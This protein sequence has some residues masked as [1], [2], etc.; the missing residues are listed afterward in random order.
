MI[1]LPWLWMQQ[2]QG[3]KELLRAVTKDVTPLPAPECNHG[4]DDDEGPP[5]RRIVLPWRCQWQRAGLAKCLAELRQRFSDLGG[6]ASVGTSWALGAPHAAHLI[7]RTCKVPSRQ[8]PEEAGEEARG[9]CLF[10]QYV[11]DL[12]HE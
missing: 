5:Q 12:L 3:Q 10:A 4:S 9:S 8:R 11:R 1:P 7:R 2:N 6:W